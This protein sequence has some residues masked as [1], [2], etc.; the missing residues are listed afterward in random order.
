VHAIST[1]NATGATYTRPDVNA[2]ERLAEL[3]IELPELP[4]FPAGPQPLIE[5]VMVHGG[6]GYLSGIGPIGTTG[7]LGG[8]M[9]VDD[10]R[11]AARVT[12]LL[13]L[14]RIKDALG[15]LEAVERWLKVTGF[16]RS[17]PGF[18]QQPLVMNG[19]TEQIV[20]I[21]GPERGRCA[22]SALGTSE[23]PMNIPVE[24][25]AIVALRP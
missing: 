19:F 2:D 6:L 25:E 9:S 12:A 7:V 1:R 15:S 17:A 5:S 20:E 4:P 11:E 10:G 8:D 13:A 14:R 16:V 23:L 21:Y 3:G 22:R 18:A 24:V